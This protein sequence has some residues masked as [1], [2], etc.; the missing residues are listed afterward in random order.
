MHAHTHA[1]LHMTSMQKLSIVPGNFSTSLRRRTGGQDS[2]ITWW[3]RHLATE[4]EAGSSVL[5]CASLIGS[6]LRDPSGP[7]QLCSSMMVMVAAANAKLSLPEGIRQV[8]NT[9]YLPDK[10]PPR[11]PT[12]I[13]KYLHSMRWAFYFW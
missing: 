12:L 9:L 3:F 7:F 2:W 6:G 8:R 11:F 5:H 10:T 1:H 13:V 4:S